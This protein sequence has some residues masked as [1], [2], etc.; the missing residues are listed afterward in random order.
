MSSLLSLITLFLIHITTSNFIKNKEN[1]YELQKQIISIQSQFIVLQQENKQLLQENN[2]I[3]SR[4][5]KLENNMQISNSCEI[6]K[7]DIEKI[8]LLYNEIYQKVEQLVLKIKEQDDSLLH[9]RNSQTKVEI[10]TVKIDSQVESFIANQEHKVNEFINKSSIDYSDFA[11][12]ILRKVNDL[13]TD[14]TSFK[15][16]LDTKLTSIN[17]GIPNKIYDYIKSK[18]VAEYKYPLSPR[19]QKV[20]FKIDDEINFEIHPNSYY[21][22]YE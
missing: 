15:D 16:V 8:N 4:L 6:I 14:F 18:V 5:N 12:G 20:V 19:I 21:Q 1:D 11:N 13:M 10:K 2:Q 22:K 7:N 9:S 3:R 17:D